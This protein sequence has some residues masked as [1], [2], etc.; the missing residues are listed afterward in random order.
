MDRFKIPSKIVV[1]LIMAV[2]LSSHNKDEKANE[3][4]KVML[5][6]KEHKVNSLWGK[7]INFI[8]KEML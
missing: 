1:G 2:V 6:G 3:E 5:W 8:E 7:G 4:S